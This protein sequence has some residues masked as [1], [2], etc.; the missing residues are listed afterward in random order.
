[1]GI[2]IAVKSELFLNRLFFLPSEFSGYQQQCLVNKWKRN[3]KE[4]KLRVTVL[5][6]CSEGSQMLKI[7]EVRGL[8]KYTGA[9]VL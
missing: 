3:I 8:C 2:G 5:I 7:N 4:E 1:M 6:F 9:S